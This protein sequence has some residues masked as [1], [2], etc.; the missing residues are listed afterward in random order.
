MGLVWDA[1]LPRDEK[2]ILLSYADHADHSGDS[3]FPSV[4]LMEWKTGYSVR[5]IQRIT[6]KLVEKE[7]L[8]E[9]GESRYGTNYY[10]IDLEKLP[11]REPFNMKKR[12]RP[13]NGDILSLDKN[14]GDMSGD[15]GDAQ[16]V[17]GDT[18]ESYDPSLNLK[19]SKD[20]IEQIGGA[21]FYIFSLVGYDF[22]EADSKTKAALVQLI[23]K[24]GEYKLCVM[25]DEYKE[26]IPDIELRP[27]LARIADKAEAYVV[28]IKDKHETP[29]KINY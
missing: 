26:K 12:G 16:D 3:V 13:V 6:K 25:A 2:Y 18:A 11:P 28:D 5:Q 23:D 21:G 7:I 19:P 1:D 9:A 24:Y 29:R 17:N 10:Q 20:N 27:L 14:N 22:D 4:P 15:N 8:V